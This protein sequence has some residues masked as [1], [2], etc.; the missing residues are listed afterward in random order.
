MRGAFQPNDQRRA[1][2]DTVG[3]ACLDGRGKEQIMI[4]LLHIDRDKLRDFGT[5]EA[6]DNHYSRPILLMG[7]YKESK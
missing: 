5:L 2:T 1:T 3:G 6:V 4:S 7:R